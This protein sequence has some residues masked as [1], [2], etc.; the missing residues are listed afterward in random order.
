MGTL[1]ALPEWGSVARLA[2]GLV[3]PNILADAADGIAI[4][5]D[6]VASLP[7]VAMGPTPE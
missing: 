1:A 2:T 4:G 5:E 7:S 3:H 6:Q